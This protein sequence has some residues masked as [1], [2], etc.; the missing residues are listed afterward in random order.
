MR[1]CKRCRNGEDLRDPA[2]VAFVACRLIPPVQVP[3]TKDGN[4]VEIAQRVAEMKPSGWCGQ[5]RLSLWKLIRPWQA[6]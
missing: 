1:A 6:S 4:T 5:F 2:G 3:I